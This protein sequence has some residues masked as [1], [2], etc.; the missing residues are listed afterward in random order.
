MQ[1]LRHRWASRFLH[2]TYSRKGKVVW[3][4]SKLKRTADF[5]FAV[6]P[7]QYINPIGESVNILCSISIE[8]DFEEARIRTGLDDGSQEG[9]FITYETVKVPL[10]AE[11]NTTVV[12]WRNTYQT[13]FDKVER[14]LNKDTIDRLFEQI[15]W[16]REDEEEDEFPVYDV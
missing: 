10:D 3:D 1:N 11:Q 9:E 13:M 14:A 8:G 2:R 6:L 15:D 12:E 7:G 5:M 16:E 4:W